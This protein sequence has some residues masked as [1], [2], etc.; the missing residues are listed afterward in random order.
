MTASGVT[1][2]ELLDQPHLTPE[3]FVHY[4]ADFKFR[5]GCTVQSPSAFLASKAG[6]CDDFA[7]LASSVLREKGYTTHMVA[8]FMDQQVHVVCY[9]TETKSFLD[10]N[11]RDKPHPLVASDGS[12][13]D[14]AAKVAGYFHSDWLSASEFVYRK[15]EPEF[16]LTDFH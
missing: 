14:I 10:Y 5:L 1:L 9:V 3:Q 15:G 6:D 12:L 16:V 8:V 7:A 11:Y 13:K 4:F 2:N